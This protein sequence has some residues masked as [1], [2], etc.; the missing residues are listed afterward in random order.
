ME[1][2]EL[3]ESPYILEEDATTSSRVAY[4][5][6]FNINGNVPAK[7]KIVNDLAVLF[8]VKFTFHDH[9]DYI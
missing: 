9:L 4:T 7:T 5:L 8:N 1:T 3:P 2:K 6:T